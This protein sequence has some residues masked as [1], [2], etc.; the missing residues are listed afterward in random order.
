ME[1]ISTT[2][3]YAY[4]TTV[5]DYHGLLGALQKIVPEAHIAGGAVRDTIL[6]KPIADIDVFV[7]D[8]HLE[9]AAAFL[10]SHGYK[11]VGAWRERY[12]FSDPLFSPSPMTRHAKFE[13]AGKTLPISLVEAGEP[14]PIS[15]VGVLPE[16]ANPKDNIGRFDF[17]IC[18]AAF[19]NFKIIQTAE[20]EQDAK[21]KTFTLLYAGHRGQFALSMHRFRKITANRYKDWSLVI[22]GKFAWHM[23]GAFPRLGDG[24]PYQYQDVEDGLPTEPPAEASAA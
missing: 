3:D 15:L 7:K 22:P 23:R 8:E 16:F 13:K 21:A 12:L 19:V 6:H 4:T 11:K 18:Q 1:A 20:F 10:C 14:L 5:W 9:Q 17:G 2:L 24:E